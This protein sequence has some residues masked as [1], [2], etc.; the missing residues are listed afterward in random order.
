MEGLYTPG[1]Q[2]P[3]AQVVLHIPVAAPQQPDG[4]ATVVEESPQAVT[5]ESPS[6]QAASSPGSSLAAGASPAACAQD[7]ECSAK[8][9][10]VRTREGGLDEDAESAAVCQETDAAGLNLAL[11]GLASQTRADVRE[12][13][14]RRAAKPTDCGCFDFLSLANSFHLR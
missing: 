4:L 10:S 5:G 13:R 12:G 8:E 2:Y 3:G 11:D 14:T 9:E 7:S 1:G 6:P